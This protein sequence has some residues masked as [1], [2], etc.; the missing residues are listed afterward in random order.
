[1]KQTRQTT[2]ADSGA[3]MQVDLF[4]PTL[5]AWFLPGAGHWLLG[6]RRRA[7]LYCAAVLGLFIGGALLGNL[8]VVSFEYHPYAFLLHL[9][10]G[11]ASVVM[12]LITDAMNPVPN[13]TRIGDIGMTMTWIAGALNVLL[14]ADVL[15]RANG[16][17]YESEK[18]KPSLTRR[19]WL[20]ITGRKK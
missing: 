19:V 17:P 13:P 11:A 3:R 20:R 8:A 1:M 4:F 15:D 16:G 6:M 9:C 2:P 7:V 10:T 14:I 5:L 12:T 18:Q